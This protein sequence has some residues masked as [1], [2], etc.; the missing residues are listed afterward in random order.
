[1]L[2]YNSYQLRPFRKRVNKSRQQAQK[3]TFHFQLHKAIHGGWDSGLDTDLPGK[4]VIYKQ[5]PNQ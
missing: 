3:T 4:Y 1:M 5:A 2:E